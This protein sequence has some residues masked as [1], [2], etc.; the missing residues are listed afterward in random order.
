M[1]H[2]I[3]SAQAEGRLQEVLRSEETEDVAIQFIASENGIPRFLAARV[4]RMLRTG[5]ERRSN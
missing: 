5:L 4:Y 2:T 1:F 3:E